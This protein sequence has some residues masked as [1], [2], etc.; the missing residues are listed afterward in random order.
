MSNTGAYLDTNCNITGDADEKREIWGKKLV[1]DMVM[2]MYPSFC[3]ITLSSFSK[4]EA[5]I[6]RIIETDDM[7]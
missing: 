7:N 3:I 4:T 1:R 6:K 5:W 2:I